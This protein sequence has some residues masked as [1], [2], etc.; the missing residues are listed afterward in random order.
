MF[1]YQAISLAREFEFVSLDPNALQTMLSILQA[2]EANCE[3]M[4]LNFWNLLFSH[5]W[6]FLVCFIS[7]RWT[8]GGNSIIDR[9][10]TCQDISVQR[11]TQCQTKASHH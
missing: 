8:F 10:D 2:Q 11:E 7:N 6:N 9:H 4:I 3:S 5:F 1:S